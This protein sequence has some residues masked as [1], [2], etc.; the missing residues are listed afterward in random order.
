[1]HYRTAEVSKESAPPRAQTT[2]KAQAS[3][4]VTDVTV[5]E[6]GSGEKGSGMLVR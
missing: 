6:Y 3:A 4:Y 1:M 2:E 5:Q